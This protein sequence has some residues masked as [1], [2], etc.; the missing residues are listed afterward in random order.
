MSKETITVAHSP[1]SD[2]ASMSQDGDKLKAQ[3]TDMGFADPDTPLARI[4]RACTWVSISR[5]T[6]A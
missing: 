2:D 1:D 4:G 3:L 5:T 6:M